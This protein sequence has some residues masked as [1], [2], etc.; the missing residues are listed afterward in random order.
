[1]IKLDPTALAAA[2]QCRRELADHGF[3]F[4]QVEEIDAAEDGG[5][6]EVQAVPLMVAGKDVEQLFRDLLAHHEDEAGG[7]NPLENH[8]AIVHHILATLACHSAVR[9][10]EELSATDWLAL[11]AAAE[12]V[13]F[14]HNCPHG[15]RVFK[16]FSKREV[17]GWFD[18]I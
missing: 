13:D 5:W 16:W 1:L 3:V 8:R 11:L 9:A 17:E 10:G 12:Q 14:Y 7:A 4:R 6:I 15:R 2:Q 18:R